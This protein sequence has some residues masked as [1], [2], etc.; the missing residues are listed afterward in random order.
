MIIQIL[1]LIVADQVISDKIICQKM[2]RKFRF[3]FMNIHYIDMSK[4]SGINKKSVLMY[5]GAVT[6]AGIAFM[7]VTGIMGSSPSFYRATV[8]LRLPL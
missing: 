2:T 8:S 4:L 1:T 7:L 6:V 3:I 5:T